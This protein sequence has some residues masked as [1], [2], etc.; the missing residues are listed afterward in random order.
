MNQYHNNFMLTNG[1]PTGLAM[2]MAMN[3]NAINNYSKLTEYEKEKLVA[4]SKNV[5]SKTEMNQI[6]KNLGDGLY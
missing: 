4:D 5:K 3:E 2:G 1:L 6:I